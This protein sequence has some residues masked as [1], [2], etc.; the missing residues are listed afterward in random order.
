MASCA[1]RVEHVT[2]LVVVNKMGSSGQWQPR[3]VGCKGD[4]TILMLY[5]QELKIYALLQL[6]PPASAS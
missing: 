5:G 4:R 2:A 3:L 1:C 6:L